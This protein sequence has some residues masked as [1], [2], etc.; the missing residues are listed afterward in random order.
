MKE[1][2]IAANIA[3]QKC[4][5]AKKFLAATEPKLKNAENNANIAQAE[6]K[7]TQDQLV[8]M[9]SREMWF[10]ITRLLLRTKRSWRMP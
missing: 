6:L 2:A 8:A 9:P 3:E 1:A 4:S 10:W 5:N 7:I